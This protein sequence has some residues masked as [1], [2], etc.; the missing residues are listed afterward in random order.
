VY[1]NST[2][3][4]TLRE[5]LSGLNGCQI[6]GDDC[7][8]VAGVAYHSREVIPGGVFVA[9]PGQ[10]TD[11]RRFVPHA[12]G[13]GARV[14]VSEHDLVPSPDTTLVRVPNARLALAHISAAFYDH[15]SRELALIGIT[16][17]NGKTTTAFL[18]EAILRQ[19]G[20]RVGVLGTVN[21]RVGERV[22]P[23]P[24]TTPESLDLNRFLRE[25]RGHGATHAL[26][27]VSSHA[28]D[29]KR[30]D[31]VAFVAGVFTNLSQDHLDYHVNLDAYFSAKSRLFLEILGNGRS[32]GGLAVLNLDDPRGR[33]LHQQV[34]V[35]A[36]TYGA[37]PVSQ[38]RP[39]AATFHREGLAAR[40]AT[41]Q[42]EMEVASRLVGPFNLANILAATA[43]ALGL[44]ISPDAIIQGIASLAGVPGRLERF[45]PIGGPHVFV[46]YAHT[47]D[48]LASV[49]DALTSLVF[50]RLLTVFGCGGDRDRSKRPLMGQA[51]AE[52]SDLVVVTS[53]NPRREDPIAIIGEIEAG[54]KDMGYPL[55][56]LAQARRGER[57]Y[58]VV[59]DR[60]EAIRLAV[61]LAAPDDGVLVAG[62]GH[63]DYQIIGA[64]RRHFDDREE[65]QAALR[66]RS[67][68][69]SDQ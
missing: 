43:T 36:L 64:E 41:P 26:L 44:G 39:L 49:L 53:D 24:V 38:V 55:L 7:L 13:K 58:L 22:W 56:S 6:Q 51:A 5:L 60:R 20:H 35:P 12:L 21:Y 1:S 52:A 29:L 45:G 19:A 30:V 16:G 69:V 68:V 66:D 17:T 34:K 15:P 27:E 54:L 33:D 14:I 37:H 25:M 61:S 28:L 10:Q 8:S 63:E 42:G 3:V 32:P 57:G 46:D 50:P 40:L 2:P 23:A 65:V 9:I 67:P 48:A 59:P 11:G 62:K 18:L 31:R 47:P 4:K